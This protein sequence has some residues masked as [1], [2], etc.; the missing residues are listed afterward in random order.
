MPGLRTCA[1]LLTALAAGLGPG[2]AADPATAPATV[3]AD[4]G[5]LGDPAPGPA[6]IATGLIRL[7]S[8]DDLLQPPHLFRCTVVRAMAP[9]D[10]AR[11][12]CTLD[13]T[14]TIDG[15]TVAT[16]HLDLDHLGQ[17]APG[18][19]LVFAPVV[20]APAA[21]YVSG[22]KAGLTSGVAN[23]V[24]ADH[25]ELTISLTDA[26][27]QLNEHLTHVVMLPANAED[28][29]T[30]LKQE[31][32][33]QHEHH[34][35]P[36]LWYEQG[37]ELELSGDARALVAINTELFHWTVGKR[38]PPSGPF[39]GWPLAPGLPLAG[40]A[41][42]PD[43]RDGSVQPVRWH[44]PA[45]ALT[46]VALWC[47]DPGDPPTKSHWQEPPAA[48]LDA[49]LA[50]GVAVVEIYPAGD[51]KWN[52][53]ALARARDLL[54]F[55]NPGKLPLFL[56]GSG[57]GAT[58]ALVLASLPPPN[59][60][61]VLLISPRLGLAPQAPVP[62]IAADVALRCDVGDSGDPTPDP[63]SASPL[64]MTADQAAFW[65]L[66]EPG[67]TQPFA[68]LTATP[69]HAVAENRFDPTGD[70]PPEPDAA[71][72][73]PFD[74]GPLTSYAN[75]PF[76]IVVGT[77]ES[78]AA[79]A[80]AET[81]ARS[82]VTAWAHHAHGL[83]PVIRDRDYRHRDWRGHHL[84]LIGN[85]LSNAV[86][87]DLAD[88]LELPVTW[89]FRT[90][91]VKIPGKTLAVLRSEHRPL[92]LAVPSPRHD[93]TSILILDG[94]PSW[95]EDPHQ[96][97]L[98]LSTFFLPGSAWPACVIGDATVANDP[99]APEPGPG[100]RLRHDDAGTWAELASGAAEG[101]SMMPPR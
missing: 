82:F 58:G 46:T 56:V 14:L 21:G 31:L 40:E 16:V 81:L 83:P 69:A 48:Q 25:G 74:H 6:S 94:A 13:A 63:S 80:D 18:A 77:G 53:I 51:R 90:E 49:A 66:P 72:A 38:P 62:V 64:M 36:W 2:F 15:A 65:A 42:W 89:D 22:V 47:G 60:R 7:V 92:A 68:S 19:D 75:G 95:P 59:L 11:G 23:S 55:V 5:V 45:G 84:V 50:A 30:R 4:F 54:P 41:A 1:I 20:P 93:G 57:Y 26:G 44:R 27:R 91:I 3:W 24:L 101:D 52:G 37:R 78:V 73:N 70:P 29:L 34:P 88:D 67:F 8:C 61:A 10:F 87:K 86:I 32:Q 79:A 39:A 35:L 12:P 85:P 33:Y 28:M 100:I 99:G 71:L 76:V 96:S 43:P 97:P 98:P 9:G 17:L